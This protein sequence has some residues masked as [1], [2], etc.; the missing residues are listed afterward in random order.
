M[1]KRFP[2]LHRRLGSPAAGSSKHS[3]SKVASSGR[4]HGKHQKP[5]GIHGKLA[6]KMVVNYGLTMVQ[7]KME[8]KEGKRWF[9]YGSTMISMLV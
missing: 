2:F 6:W 5:W 4:H 9:T 1:A 7:Q 8:Q 3:T